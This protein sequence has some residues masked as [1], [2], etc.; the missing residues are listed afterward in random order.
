MTVEVGVLPTFAGTVPI[1]ARASSPA[2]F[3]AA[4]ASAVAPPSAREAFRSVT[5]FTSP[6]L[7]FPTVV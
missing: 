1:R 6:L 7:A 5:S 3:A 2:F 4:M